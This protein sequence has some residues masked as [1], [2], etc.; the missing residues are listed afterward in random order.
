MWKAKPKD[1]IS[2]SSD[3]VL[4][5]LVHTKIEIGPMPI[6][7]NICFSMLLGWGFVPKYLFS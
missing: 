5:G 4:K 1:Q 3:Q 7:V 6:N 2:I